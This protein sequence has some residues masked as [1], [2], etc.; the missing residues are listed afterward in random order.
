MAAVILVLAED[1]GDTYRAPFVNS[2][3]RAIDALTSD[4][5]AH[6]VANPP[7][8]PPVTLSVT[9]DRDNDDGSGAGSVPIVIG[10]PSTLPS[11]GNWGGRETEEEAADDQSDSRGEQRQQQ[12]QQQQR[13]RRAQ[14]PQ[15]NKDIYLLVCGSKRHASHLNM[16]DAVPSNLA[17]GGSLERQ[18]HRSD[19][20]R[21]WTSGEQIFAEIVNGVG[22]GRFGPRTN[23]WAQLIDVGNGQ[24]LEDVAKEVEHALT[25]KYCDGV[26]SV[27]MLIPARSLSGAGGR[28]SCD[29]GESSGE[30]RQ[31]PQLVQDMDLGRIKQIFEAAWGRDGSI[32]RHAR[33][34]FV[35]SSRD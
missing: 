12:Q 33:V 9:S 27:Y 17:V 29:A 24:E 8:P 6:T 22:M 15:P 7:L 34:E 19:W 11:R 35:T 2:V 13:Q 28:G 30:Q 23:L 31:E 20:D 4:D 25:R 5:D 18:T 32:L 14:H 21:A 16:N 1:I 10:S 3:V 26:A